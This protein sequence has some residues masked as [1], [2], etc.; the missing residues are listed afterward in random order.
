M[1]K[2]IEKLMITRAVNSLK[3]IIKVLYNKQFGFMSGCNTSDAILH[4]ADD[5]V[6]ALDN[7]LILLAFFGL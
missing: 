2:I 4:F 7:K 5:C 1:A 6:T 3:I